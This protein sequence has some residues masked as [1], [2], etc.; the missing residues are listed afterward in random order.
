MRRILDNRGPPGSE[1][2]DDQR[3][4]MFAKM[5]GGPSTGRPASGAASRVKW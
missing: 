3:K 2:E 5:G 1:M 4:A